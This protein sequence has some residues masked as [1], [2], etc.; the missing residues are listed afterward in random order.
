MLFQT[1]HL[2]AYPYGAYGRFRPTEP[3]IN[4]RYV[5]VANVYNRDPLGLNAPPPPVV[6]APPPVAVPFAKPSSPSP[7]DSPR[8]SPSDTLPQSSPTASS[9][10]QSHVDQS[11]PMEIDTPTASPVSDSSSSDDIDCLAPSPQIANHLDDLLY[12][13]LALSSS[14]DSDDENDEVK[15]I[16]LTGEPENAPSRPEET[17]VKTSVAATNNANTSVA[18]VETE[19]SVAAA[20]TANTAVNAET[21]TSVTSVAAPELSTAVATTG[22]QTAITVDQLAEAILPPTGVTAPVPTVALIE[23]PQV[24]SFANDTLVLNI[25]LPDHLPPAM[26]I[27]RVIINPGHSGSAP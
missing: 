17:T 26:K 5:D 12:G 7:R 9:P 18:A 27:I 25:E 11:V 4:D 10:S 3:A 14:D 13:D 20:K 1:E 16:D 22:T 6:G 2:V 21:D 8:K 23:V 15:I 19:E 24:P